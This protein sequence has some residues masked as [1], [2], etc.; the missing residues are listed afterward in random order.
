M[1]ARSAEPPRDERP[2]T[3]VLT[4]RDKHRKGEPIS[5][6]TAYDFPTARAVD[7]AGVDGILVGDSLAM[8]VLGHPNTLSVTMDEMLHHARAVSRGAHARSPDRRPAVPEL[9]GGRGRSGPQRRPLPGRGRAWTPSSWR[10]ASAFVPTIRRDRARGHPGT[11]PHRP[12][13]PARERAGRLQGPGPDAR[14]RRSVLLDD[15]LRAG[16]RGLLLDRAGER[17]R[18]PGRLHHRPAPHPHHRH[19]RRARA[20]R[21]GPGACTTSSAFTAATPRSSSSATPSWARAITRGGRPR[22][23]RTWRPA[24]SRDPSIVHDGGRGV[25]GVPRR[26][27]RAAAPS[28]ARARR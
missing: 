20:P 25:A 3:T 4:F 10:A 17:P 12:H 19:R 5:L 24:R 13:A 11:G 26:R 2:K 7:D 1:S 15:A 27:R 9:P 14:T 21:P 28:G 22:T 23:A 6:V 16:G 8:V 18:P